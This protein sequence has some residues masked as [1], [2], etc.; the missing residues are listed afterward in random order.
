VTPCSLV[1]VYPH[2]EPDWPLHLTAENRVQS[3]TS[4]SAICGGQIGAVVDF[5]PHTISVFPW[6]F[7]VTDARVIRLSSIDAT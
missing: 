1:D 7:R 4:P 3:Q 2:V 5:S 6:Q